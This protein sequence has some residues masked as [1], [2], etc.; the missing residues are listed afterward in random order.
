MEYLRQINEKRNEGVNVNLKDIKIKQREMFR[1]YDNRLKERHEKVH[2]VRT[3]LK[4]DM[5]TRKELSLLRKADQ[6]ENY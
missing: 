6:E 1:Y 4:E 2:E 3:V 5:D